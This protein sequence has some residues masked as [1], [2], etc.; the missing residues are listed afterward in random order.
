MDASAIAKGKFA[1]MNMVLIEK[2]RAAVLD[3]LNAKFEHQF[4][5]LQ[6]P[7]HRDNVN[8]LLGAFG[9]FSVPTKLGPAR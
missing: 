2:Q 3:D 9:Q 8:N 7:D 5:T 4:S 1:G 6:S